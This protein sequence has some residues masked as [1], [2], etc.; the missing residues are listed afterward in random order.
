MWRLATYR[1]VPI[2]AT[3]TRARRTCT[4]RSRFELLRQQKLS[5]FLTCTPLSSLSTGSEPSRPVVA[6]GSTAWHHFRWSNLL[7]RWS[8]DDQ[9]KIKRWYQ[10]DL[11][12]DDH[13]MIWR[14]SIDDLEMIK[15]RSEDDEKLPIDEQNKWPVSGTKSWWGAA[16]RWVIDVGDRS[17]IEKDLKLVCLCQE[18]ATAGDFLSPWIFI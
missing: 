15:R 10:G 6:M 13:Q 5:T 18:S 9:E 7:S 16:R 14:W 2:P 17:A 8:R 3:V 1:W 11:H 4:P 12:R